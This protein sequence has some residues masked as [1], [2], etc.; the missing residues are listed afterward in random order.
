MTR[1][2]GQCLCGAVS[3]AAD[4]P[5]PTFLACHCGQCRR[6]TGGGPFYAIDVENAELSGEAVTE[7]FASDWGA[8]GYCGTCGTTLYW[9]MRDR[10]ITSLAVGILDDQSGL[11]LRQEIFSDCRAGWMQPVPGTAQSTE[12]EE[13]AKLDEY[14]KTGGNA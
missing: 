12:A 9:R 3:V 10:G 6:W 2:T 8:R 5:D 7:Y 13:M 1:R 14:L 4:I 11:S